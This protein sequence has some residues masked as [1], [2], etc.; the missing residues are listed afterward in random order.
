MAKVNEVV[1]ERSNAASEEEILFRLPVDSQPWA[2][3]V[4]STNCTCEARPISTGA[5][6]V[7]PAIDRRGYGDV[8][9]WK[10]QQEE[11]GKELWESPAL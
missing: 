10:K 2:V 9:T 6:M 5:D 11:E 4:R 7:L 8:C 1:C 3:V